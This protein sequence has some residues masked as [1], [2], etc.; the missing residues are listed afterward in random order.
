MKPKFLCPHC[1][2]HLLLRD[3][4]IL[5]VVRKNQQKSIFLLNPD[6]GNY[7]YISSPDFKFEQGEQVEFRCPV[8]CKNLAAKKINDKLVNLLMI[9]SDGKEYNVYFSS[10]VGE[11]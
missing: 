9:G 2:A 5:K 10:I 11:Q 4:V 7:T 3:N 6:L 8:C 1:E